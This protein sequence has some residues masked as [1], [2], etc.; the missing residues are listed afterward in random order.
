MESVSTVEGLYQLLIGINNIRS[1]R[2]RIDLDPLIH[3]CLGC[4]HTILMDPKQSQVLEMIGDANV[5]KLFAE[6]LSEPNVNFQREAAGILAE[7]VMVTFRY[8]FLIKF[9]KNCKNPGDRAK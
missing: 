6:F 3:R 2:H 1:D 5:I 4:I 8:I 7:L 9:F